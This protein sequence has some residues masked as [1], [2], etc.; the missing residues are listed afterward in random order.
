MLPFLGTFSSSPDCRTQRVKDATSDTI[1]SIQRLLVN[2]EPSPEPIFPPGVRKPALYL[3]P[4]SDTDVSV[5]IIHKGSITAAWPPLQ[6]GNTWKVKA[7]PSGE[8]TDSAGR[9]YRYLFWEGDWAEQPRVDRNTGFVV[10]GDEVRDF[11]ARSLDALGLNHDEANDFVTYWYP[12]LSQHA[13][14]YIHFLTEEYERLVNVQM[15]PPCDSQLRVF[16][17][18]QPQEARTVVVPQK[19]KKFERRG[20]VLVEWGGGKLSNGWVRKLQ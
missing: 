10:S 18:Y 4:Q 12:V 15:D 11:L 9:G 20:F 14:V 5:R 8:L 7:R 19:L 17:T 13:F 3:Y 2:I 16:M 1:S 6:S